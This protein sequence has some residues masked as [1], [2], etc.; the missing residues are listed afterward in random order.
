MKILLSSLISLILHLEMSLVCQ[1]LPAFLSTSFQLQQF[2]AKHH[3]IMIIMVF[4]W[5]EEY[6]TLAN[7]QCIYDVVLQ[8]SL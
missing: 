3:Q 6:G 7:L 4:Q 8:A 5:I 1:L 2:N